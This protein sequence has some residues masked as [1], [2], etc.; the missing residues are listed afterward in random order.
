MDK[1]LKVMK[2]G[3]SEAGIGLM[4]SIFS[5]AIVLILGSIT[6]HLFSMA[7]KYYELKTATNIVA[8]KLESARG[9]A[10]EQG[11]PTGVIVDFKT[12]RLGVD[13][14][15]N[16][17]L[18][19]VEAEDLPASVRLSN[20]SNDSTVTFTSSGKLQGNNKEPRIVVS[21][22]RISACRRVSPLGVIEID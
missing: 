19:S 4:E 14:N 1:T 8:D 21:N 10:K 16:G 20:D 17:K 15:H 2:R 22:S 6:I 12:N 11:Q 9:L 7:Y 3:R 18:E 13:R 5:L